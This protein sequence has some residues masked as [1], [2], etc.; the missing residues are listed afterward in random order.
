[1]KDLFI[2]LAIIGLGVYVYQGY[3]EAKRQTIKLTK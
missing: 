2:T 3:R 1:M